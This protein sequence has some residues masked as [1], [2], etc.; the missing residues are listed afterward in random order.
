[1]VIVSVRK[2]R[3]LIQVR[4]KV[5]HDEIHSKDFIS[6]EKPCEIPE[7][8][9]DEATALPKR[10]NFLLRRFASR[11]LA[12]VLN[13]A[14]ARIG[15]LDLKKR[16]GDRHSSRRRAGFGHALASPHAFNMC[17]FR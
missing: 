6:E 15:S 9:G 16:K 13:P 2:S 10:A 5:I 17:D 4:F 8:P 1:L 7:E 14:H 3:F 12:G 11:K